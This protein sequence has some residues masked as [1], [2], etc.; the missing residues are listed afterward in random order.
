[1]KA[2]FRIFVAVFLQSAVLFLFCFLVLPVLGIGLSGLRGMIVVIFP[3]SSL[4]LHVSGSSH[5]VS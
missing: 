1:M 2:W 4:Y 3:S 5:E